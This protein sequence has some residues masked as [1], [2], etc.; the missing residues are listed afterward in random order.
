MR[1]VGETYKAALAGFLFL[2]ENGTVTYFT[3]SSV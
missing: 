2:E 3:I 1:W